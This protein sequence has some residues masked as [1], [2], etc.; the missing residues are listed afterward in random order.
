MHVHSALTVT[1]VHLFVLEETWKWFKNQYFAVREASVTMH[2]S[3]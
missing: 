3:S 2:L 1:V